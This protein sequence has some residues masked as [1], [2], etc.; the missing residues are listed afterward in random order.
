MTF[1][2]VDVEGMTSGMGQGVIMIIYTE[3][4][5]MEKGAVLMSEVER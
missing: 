4:K 3:K 5:V 2:A 1:N